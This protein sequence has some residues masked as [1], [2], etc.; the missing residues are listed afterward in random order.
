MK[1][2]SSDFIY[3][4]EMLKSLENVLS[5]ER[6]ATYIS[7]TEGNAERAIRLYLWNAELSESLQ[8]PVHILE[9]AVRNAIHRQLSFLYGTDWYDHAMTFT[10]FSR[11]QSERNC[12][13]YF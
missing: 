11:Q 10:L 6:L 3:T 1:S 2:L 9:V 7:L 5:P 8:M 13:S 12:S 4:S